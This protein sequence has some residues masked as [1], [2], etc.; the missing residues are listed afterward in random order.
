MYKRF[1]FCFLLIFFISAFVSCRS[2]HD[3]AY[4]SDAE[5]DS[6]QRILTTY[7]NTIHPGDQLYIY[8]N[9][10]NPQSVAPFNQ[11]MHSVVAEA[12]RMANIRGESSKPQTASTFDQR[13]VGQVPGYMVDEAGTITFP[14]LGKLHVE[15][16]TQDSLSHLIQ[17][18]LI[19]GD[20]VYDP[21]VTVNSMNFRVTVIGE[22]RR[23]RELHI[24][25]DRLT[26]LEALAM[27][28]D[29]ADSGR[30]DNVLVLREVNG[31]VIPMEVDLTKKTLFDSE[32]YYLQQNDLVYVEPNEMKK[33]RSNYDQNLRADIISYVHFGTSIVRMGYV[34]FRR[35]IMDRRGLFH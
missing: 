10:L 3:V 24:T 30:R 28:G 29:I 2:I 15:G 20:Y 31:D 32:C 35:Y 34:T 4:I 5:R 6:A 25:G 14:L 21:V 9:S 22:V 27:C 13:H 12:N 18:L 16:I 19:T 1:R 7:T 8:V 33:R 23:P 26:I 17:Q 11:E